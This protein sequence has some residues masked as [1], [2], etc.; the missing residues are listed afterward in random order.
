[1]R[2]SAC[3]YVPKVNSEAWTSPITAKRATHLSSA[4]APLW[5]RLHTLAWRGHAPPKTKTRWG[6]P[7]CLSGL[8]SHFRTRPTSCRGCLSSNPAAV[9][10][11]RSLGGGKGGCYADLLGRIWIAEINSRE[12]FALDNSKI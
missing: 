5:A 11:C 8:V 3:E 7:P 6:G 4:V 9:K 12:P 1:M 2:L 10:L